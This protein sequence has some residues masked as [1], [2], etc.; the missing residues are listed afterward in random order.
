[1]NTIARIALIFGL[2]AMLLTTPTLAGPKDYPLP[3]HVDVQFLSMRV[4]PQA[5]V[6]LFMKASPGGP[7]AQPGPIM[8]LDMKSGKTQPLSERLDKTSSS[9]R[10]VGIGPVSPDGRVVQV[11][12]A[13]QRTPKMA[14]LDLTTFAL[15]VLD[16]PGVMGGCWLGNKLAMGVMDPQ[17]RAFGPIRVHD[18]ATG[19]TV[20]LPLCGMPITASADGST[21]LFAGNAEAPRKP[22]ALAGPQDAA[23]AML[24]TS[25]PDCKTL[26]KL[27]PMDT[28]S[29]EPRISPN[30]RYVSFQTRR[31]T[32][33][34][35][36]RRLT[37][38]GKESTPVKTGQHGPP[39]AVL[40]DG[41]LLMTALM[42]QDKTVPMSLT[43]P[44]GSARPL[45]ACADACVEAG[46]LYLAQPEGKPV[47]RAE[48]L[49][50]K[51]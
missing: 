14:M 4:A 22:L 39:R 41:T 48:T 5:G 26:R 50:E 16:P 36:V 46:T 51:K 15:T 24:M 17:Q 1:M 45:P 42:H 13:E 32:G 28:V 20:Q 30:G 25:D 2:P 47:V 35:E 43:A 11:I 7:G 34:Y 31:K 21:L 40:N 27:A 6:V 19:K 8:V 44:D 38:D 49:P 12:V 37:T 29:S 33:G 18:P 3:K 10:P 23:K 9:V